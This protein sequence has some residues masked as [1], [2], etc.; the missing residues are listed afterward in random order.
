MC[1]ELE[2]ESL[3]LLIRSANNKNNH[4]QFRECWIPNCSSRSPTQLEMFKFL[5]AMIGWSIRSTSTLHLDLPPIFWKKIIGQEC[6]E[7]DLKMIDTYSWQIIQEL[8]KYLP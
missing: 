3:P 1:K 5:G 6:D 8:K 2:S 7:L 4:G